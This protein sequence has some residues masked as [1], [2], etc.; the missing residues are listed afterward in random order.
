MSFSS[1]LTCAVLKSF[2]QEASQIKFCDCLLLIPHFLNLNTTQ[3]GSRASFHIRAAC[4]FIS[5]KRMRG[6]PLLQLGETELVNSFFFF[7]LL[8]FLNT[9][10]KLFTVFL[11]PA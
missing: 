6:F 5:T 7:L 3:G 10:G 8:F 9:T 2:P 1:L 4:T 11:L